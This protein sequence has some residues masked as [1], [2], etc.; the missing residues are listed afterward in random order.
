M[1]SS[2]VGG[3]SRLKLDGDVT[4]EIDIPLSII[5]VAGLHRAT[6]DSGVGY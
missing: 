3:E 4:T 6:W 1:T 5:G 2:D